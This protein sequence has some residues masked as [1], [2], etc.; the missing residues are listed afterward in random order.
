MGKPNFSEDFKPD[1]M[2]QISVRRY[3]VREV[4]QRLGVSTYSLY[5]WSN[6]PSDAKDCT[7]RA[8]RKDGGN[9]GRR[10][11][12]VGGEEPVKPSCA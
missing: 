7:P 10:S 2:H 12:P 4:S 11:I 1:A 9:L 8:P 5:K 3:A 6:W